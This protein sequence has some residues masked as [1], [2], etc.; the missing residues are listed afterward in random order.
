K[1]DF[2]GPLVLFRKPVAY[3]EI[4]GKREPV[5][6]EFVRRSGTDTIGFFLGA[7]DHSRQ[8][9]IDPV[10]SFATYLDG[11]QND[12]ITATT[13]DAAGNVYVTGQTTSADF[14]LKNPPANFCPNCASAAT[15][16]H[17]FISKLDPTGKTLLYSTFIGGSSGELGSKIAIDSNG[18]IIVSGTSSSSDFP[19]AGSFVSQAPQINGSS[20]FLASITPDGTAFNY[21]GLLGQ[22][23]GIGASSGVM[24]LDSAGNAYL[25]GD[26]ESASFPITPG[27]L[28]TSVPGFPT[29][30]MFISK[31]APTGALAYSTIVPG[32]LTRA[33][34]LPPAW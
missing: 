29:E 9:V 2:G 13:T 7:Y 8:L 31:I 1:V 4:A 5:Q 6:A 15:I 18:N 17:A 34:P 23:G 22:Q 24:A 3:Q 11:T 12:A 33:C 25:A 26:T 27:T 21:A 30:S 16:A 28:A 32:T 10:L 14:P 19:Q 20:Y